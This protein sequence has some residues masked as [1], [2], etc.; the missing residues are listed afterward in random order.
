LTKLDERQHAFREFDCGVFNI[1]KLALSYDMTDDLFIKVAHDIRLTIPPNAKREMLAYTKEIEIFVSGRQ[2][3]TGWWFCKKTTWKRLNA[4]I[5]F[6]PYKASLSCW[7]DP[8]AP[9]GIVCFQ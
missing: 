1:L 9:D 6:N 4:E 8:K 5:T 7:T 3:Q 2:W